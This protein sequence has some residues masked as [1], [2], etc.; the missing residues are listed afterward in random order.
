MSYGKLIYDRLTYSDIFDN[1]L[2]DDYFQSK[3]LRFRQPFEIGT[4][5]S[6]RER[7]YVIVVFL[8]FAQKHHDNN[9]FFPNFK[10]LGFKIRNFQPPVHSIGRTGINFLK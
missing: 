8:R 9:L 6:N 4:D 3:I 5:L 2:I 10:S 7:K 1:L